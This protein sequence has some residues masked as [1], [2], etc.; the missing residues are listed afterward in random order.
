MEWCQK[1][2]KK[3]SHDNWNGISKKYLEFVQA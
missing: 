2:P 1:R 3:K